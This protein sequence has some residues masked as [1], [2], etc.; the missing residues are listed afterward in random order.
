LR[1]L[2]T[3]GQC[4]DQTQAD[5]LVKDFDFEFFIAD[6]GY[7][8]KDFLERLKQRGAEIVVP[9]RSNRKEPREYDVHLYRERHLVECFINQMKQ[10]RRVFSRFEKL[11]KN[12]LS[13]LYFVSAL[14]WLR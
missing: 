10:Y 9:S 8:A 6:K 5:E 2:L 11:S 1:F 3:A 14:I 12:H 4:H 7:D 13:F